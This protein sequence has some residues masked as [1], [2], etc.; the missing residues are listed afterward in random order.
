MPRDVGDRA[1]TERQG[2]RE[3]VVDGGGG[4]GGGED[5][6][7]VLEAG[8]V[9]ERHVQKAQDREEAHDAFEAPPTKVT[10]PEHGRIVREAAAN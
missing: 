7:G 9:P 3:E 8:A 5:R 6:L 2:G 10:E 1:F 4:G